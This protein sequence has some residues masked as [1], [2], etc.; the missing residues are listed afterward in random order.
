[1]LVNFSDW[2]KHRVLQTYLSGGEDVRDS[3]INAGNKNQLSVLTQKYEPQND[4]MNRS[5]F[6]DGGEKQLS[7]E[8]IQLSEMMRG[9]SSA[10]D[11]KKKA[12]KK[13][14][15]K[16]CSTIKTE[17]P[18]WKYETEEIQPPQKL[19]RYS[20]LKEVNDVKKTENDPESEARGMELSSTHRDLQLISNRLTDHNSE[21]ET[22]KISRR[23]IEKVPSNYGREL[24]SSG[25][26]KTPDSSLK[27]SDYSYNK[28]QGLHLE[29]IESI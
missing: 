1:M 13:S 9:T 20:S 6:S 15:I 21:E 5:A 17:K 10:F 4:K 16:N 12:N 2:R 24:T 27:S 3:K 11:V 29:T 26:S 22:S 28:G 7:F 18:E 25:L 23:S 19:V 14:L 8:E